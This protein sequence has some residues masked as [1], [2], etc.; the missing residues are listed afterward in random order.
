MKILM[1]VEIDKLIRSEDIDE[2]RFRAGDQVTIIGE[3]D[4]S[5]EISVEGNTANLTEGNTQIVVDK[6]LSSVQIKNVEE[7]LFH[8]THLAFG[9]KNGGSLILTF[10]EVEWKEF[11]EVIASDARIA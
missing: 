5:K 1:T 9:G 6:V 4:P 3:F 2:G 11:K 8:G 10:S 7:A